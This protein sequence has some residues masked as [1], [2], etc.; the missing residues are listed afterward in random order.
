VL[1]ATTDE[2]GE[3]TFSFSSTDADPKTITA[4]VTAGGAAID[5]NDTATIIVVNP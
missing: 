2:N 1:S 5:L 3:A 4:T